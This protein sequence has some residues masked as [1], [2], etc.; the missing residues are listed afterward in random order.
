M[1]VYEVRVSFNCE[2]LASYRQKLPSVPVVSIYN[3]VHKVLLKSEAVTGIGGTIQK[4]QL[5]HLCLLVQNSDDAET[6]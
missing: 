2:D 4:P 5:A 6:G 1:D 3:V